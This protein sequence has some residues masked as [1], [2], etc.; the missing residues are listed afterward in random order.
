MA[1]F[2]FRLAPVLRHR[3]RI[4]EEK[5]W[6]VRALQEA[7]WKME[8]EIRRLERELQETEEVVIGREGC[9]SSVKELRLYS[10]HVSWLAKWIR[11]KRKALAVFE[12]K[13]GEKRAELV[14]ALRAVKSLE[15]LRKRLE[16]K[17]HREQEIEERKMADE[18]SQQR[19][20]Y[21]GLRR[22]KLP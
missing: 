22:Q 8:E 4:K 7:R 5:Q 16:E 17:F 6:E 10:D 2:E 12:Q 20:I 11:E 1:M 9:I 19:F 15:Q 21:R 14:E 3:E 13:L 18:T